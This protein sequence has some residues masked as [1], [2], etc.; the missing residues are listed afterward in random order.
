MGWKNVKNHYQ[1]G[2]TVQVT[3]QGICIGSHYIHNIIVLNWDGTIKKR[4][5]GRGNSDLERYQEAFDSDPVKLKLLLQSPDFFSDSITVY[6]FQNGKIIE[7]LCEKPGWPGITHDGELMYGNR[8]STYKEVVIKWAKENTQL[9]ID[10]MER[11]ISEARIEIE[12]LKEI[13]SEEVAILKDLNTL[14]PD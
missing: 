8:F 4:Y 5:D 7:K 12:K 9:C 6:T 11:R 3:D 2:H 14:Y 1:I 13:F 10:S